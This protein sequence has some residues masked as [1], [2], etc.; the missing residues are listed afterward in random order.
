MEIKR[1]SII[2][3]EPN[4]P[5][6]G[7]Y[8]EIML[9]FGPLLIGSILKQHGYEVKIFEERLWPMDWD[10]ILSSDAVGIYVMTCTVRRV[11]E[12]YERIKAHNPNL[13]IFVGGTHPSEMPEDTLRFA[14][15]VVRKEGDETVLDLLDALQ[16]GRDLSTVLGL[17][18]KQDGKIIHNA[19]RPFVGNLDIIPDLSIVHNYKNDSKWKLWFQG[20]VYM[21]VIQASRGCPF[22]CSFCYGIRQLGIGY[23]M[24][25]I[26]NIIAD[27]QYRIDYSGSKRFLFVDNHFVANPKFT[28]ELLTR[29]KEEGIK[30]DWCLVFTRI[31][32]ANHEEILQLM[33]DV[34][35]T[36]LHIGL[37]SFND[38][39][40]SSYNK[41]QSRQQVIDS[42]NTI[43]KYGLRISGSFVLGTDVDTVETTRETVDMALKYG[44]HNY[45]GFSVMEFPNLSSP[46]LIPRN[47]MIIRDYDHGNGTFV[48]HFPKNMRPSILQREMNRGL[49][50]FYLYKLWEDIKDGNF[51]EL[52]FKLTH[53]S[54]YRRMARYWD[55]HVAYLEKVEQGLYDEND[56][57]IEENLGEEGIFPPDFVKAWT[58]EVQANVIHNAPVPVPTPAIRVPA[59]SDRQRAGVESRESV[60]AVTA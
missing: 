26:D 57:L 19:D 8:N 2:S 55:E 11:M 24:R 12:H 22:T 47:R 5:V 54:L 34:G 23:R 37:E 58:P 13:P 30:F 35:I 46:G 7:S 56:H 25:S 36:N 31:E 14:D 39:S 33:K 49:R 1:I 18:Y 6:G 38:T 9:V 17:S 51:R 59:R 53:F 43:R 50:K 60:A 44:V 21:N 32:V 16:T 27:I 45:I 42:L 29:I 10:Y 4:I 52:G 20:R 15:Y 28:R 40:L 41:H 3:A 48:F